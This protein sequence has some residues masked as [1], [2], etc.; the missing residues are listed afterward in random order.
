MK[1]TKIFL[2][3]LSLVLVF[4]VAFLVINA[5][6][7]ES[8]ELKP[9]EGLTYHLSSDGTFYIVSDYNHQLR[10]V[11]LVIP[12]EYNGLPVKEIANDAFADRVWL[13]SV[14]IPKSIVKIGHGAFGRSGLTKVYFNAEN[15]QDF[16]SRN[17]VFYPDDEGLM[18]MDIVIG[19]D[20]KKIPNRLFFPLDTVPT[21]N[22]IINS[23]T[24]EENSQLT[25]IG[26]YA[27][28][29]IDD[30]KSITFPASLKKIG[31]YA[32]YGNEYGNIVFNEGLEVIEEHA[33]DNSKKVK[34]ITLPNSI[35]SVGKAAFRNCLLLQSVSSNS[36]SYTALAEHTF[37]YCTKLTTVNLPNVTEIKESAF[38]GCTSLASYDMPNIK[39][40]GET[41]FRNCTGMT[42]IT[43]DTNLES[44]GNYAFEGCTNVEEIVIKSNKLNDLEAANGAFYDCGKAKE[45]ILVL[46]TGEVTSLPKRLFLSS[47]NSANL[48]NIKEVVINTQSLKLIDD[49]A[50]G[51]IEA[52]VTYVGTKTMWSGV[53]V[54]VGNNCF[55]KVNCVK[56]WVGE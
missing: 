18:S 12:E 51:Y 45:G 8:D 14:Y 40:I 11:D 21:L 25:E 2:M 47:S 53:T 29:N 3:T 9:S 54:N 55:G 16:D 7:R 42:S 6:T 15:C 49:Y 36:T 44:I 10:D 5:M 52:S 22:P 31:K 4:S 28:Y 33:F 17:W 41:A 50:F 37:K 56:E 19:K 32:F 20:V 30:T 1:K 48:P 24:F 27:F 39:K 13:K 35:V 26:M 38:E 34:D 46:V 23:I 43:L